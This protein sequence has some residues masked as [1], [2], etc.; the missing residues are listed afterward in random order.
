MRTD[1]NWWCAI[2][3]L[4]EPADE[5]GEECFGFGK[6]VGM[7]ECVRECNGRVERIRLTAQ[8]RARAALRDRRRRSPPKCGTAFLDA[9]HGEVHSAYNPTDAPTVFVATFLEA[10]ADGP[11][12]ITEGVT[13]AA[14]DC[15]LPTS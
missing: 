10:P 8:C 7:S 3:L 4:V 15:G 1:V 12:V 5:R 11:L 9:G 2:S 14:D 6:P 13:A